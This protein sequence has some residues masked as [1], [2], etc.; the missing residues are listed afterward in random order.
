MRL[1]ERIRRGASFGARGFQLQLSRNSVAMRF[2]N[3]EIAFQ[4]VLSRSQWKK[5]IGVLNSSFRKPTNADAYA[6]FIFSVGKPIFYVFKPGRTLE[7]LE[8]KLG[9]HVSR[10]PHREVVAIRKTNWAD[11]VQL[12]YGGVN[13]YVKRPKFLQVLKICLEFERAR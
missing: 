9:F 12:E 11:P 4:F 6:G 13:F 3:G 5:F 2:V 8:K 1:S 7:A 10:P